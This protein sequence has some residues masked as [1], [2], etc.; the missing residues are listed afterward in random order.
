MSV[1][2]PKKRCKSLKSNAT[3]G[4]YGAPASDRCCLPG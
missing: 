3:G 4:A 2:T 1:T